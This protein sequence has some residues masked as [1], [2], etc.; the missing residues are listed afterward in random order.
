ME[1]QPG[2]WTQRCP[3]ASGH[4]SVCGHCYTSSGASPSVSTV[5]RSRHA[6]Y[7][8]WALDTGESGAESSA[9]F[10]RSP[11][12]SCELCRSS[13]LNTPPAMGVERGRARGSCQEWCTFPT[14]QARPQQ[15]IA[16][17]HQSQ[18]IP[19]ARLSKDLGHAKVGVRTEKNEKEMRTYMKPSRPGSGSLSR[20]SRRRACRSLR[21]GRSTCLLIGSPGE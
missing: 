14:R 1:K 7:A 5:S 6:A 10:W 13:V 11:R 9:G 4:E 8:R 21:R 16:S 12:S 18:V 15:A 19:C 2:G 3:L 17:A 20:T